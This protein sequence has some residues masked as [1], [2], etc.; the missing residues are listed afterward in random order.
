MQGKKLLTYFR[1]R[2][3]CEQK[4]WRGKKF[5]FCIA[6]CKKKVLHFANINFREYFLS[7]LWENAELRKRRNIRVI[8]NVIFSKW[9]KFTKQALVCGEN[10]GKKREKINRKL[11]GNFGNK[12]KQNFWGH[13]LSR[14]WPKFMTFEKVSAPKIWE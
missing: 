4:L 8:F 5:L 7:L 12:L 6:K 9:N 13:K 2:I 14:I 11:W 3:F 10:A 1:R